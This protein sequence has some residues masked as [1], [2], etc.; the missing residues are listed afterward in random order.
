MYINVSRSSRR[1][2]L[3]PSETPRLDALRTNIRIKK[4]GNGIN[5]VSAVGKLFAN[6]FIDVQTQFANYTLVETLVLPLFL[7]SRLME[8]R[9]TEFIR[10]LKLL[11]M[12]RFLAFAKGQETRE[13]FFGQ[14]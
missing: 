12:L 13:T 10:L 6:I 2:A 1:L 3:A 14:H 8:I 7:N 5:A 4:K 11:W 9:R